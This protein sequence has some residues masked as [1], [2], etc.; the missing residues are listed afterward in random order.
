M[1][2]S[3]QDLRPVCSIAPGNPRREKWLY[4]FQRLDNIP[5]TSWLPTFADVVGRGREEIH[6]LD[7]SRVTP[8]ERERLILTLSEAFNDPIEAVAEAIETNGLPVLAAQIIVAIP[9]RLFN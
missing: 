2:Q 1:N 8:A 9:L 3:P 6:M 5:I 7:F 4:V